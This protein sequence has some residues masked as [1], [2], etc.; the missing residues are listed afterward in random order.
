MHCCRL[1]QC[2]ITHEIIHNKP[3]V[4][5][6]VDPLTNVIINACIFC[7]RDDGFRYEAFENLLRQAITK[8]KLWPEE[9]MAAT[10]LVSKFM[11]V[12]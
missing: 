8:V 3:D 9:I 11:E 10:V 12:F 4:A 5:E 6:G 7:L 2:T 1:P